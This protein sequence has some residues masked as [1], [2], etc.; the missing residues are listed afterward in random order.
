MM[1]RL[2]TV[3]LLSGLLTSLMALSIKDIQYTTDASGDSPYKDQVVTVSG[4]VTAEPYAFDGR[5]FFIQDSIGAWSGVM[6]YWSA[7]PDTLLISE[8]DWVTVTGTVKEY[9]GVTEIADITAFSIDEEAVFSIEPIDVTTG[10]VA[11]DGENAESYEGVLVRVND[12]DI[13][14]DMNNYGEWNVNDGSGDLMVDDKADFYFNPDEYEDCLSIT[15]VMDYSYSNFR[16]YP[17]LAWDI[18]EG[19]KTGEDKIYTRIQ[20]IQQ[21]R[22]SDLVK[23]AEG[24]GT[25]ASYMAEADIDNPDTTIIVKGVVTMPTGLS[26]AGDGIKFILQDLEGGPWSSILSYNEDS[27]AYP[28]LYEGDLIEMTGFVGEYS[29]G[30]ANMTEFWLT[31]A[32]EILDYGLETPVPDT[33]TTG[34]IRL[35]QTAEQYGNNMVTVVDAIV[36]ELDI[37]YYIM[38]IDDGTGQAL[39][40]DDSDSLEGYIAPPLMTPI[41]SITGWV[42]HHYGSYADSTTYNINPLYMDDI[43]LGDGPAMLLDPSRSPAG[44]IASTDAVT[45]GVTIVTNREIVEAKVF[46]RVDEGDYVGLDLVKDLDDG[47]HY[48]EIPQQ[49]DHAFVDYYFYVIDNE[50]D[51]SYLPANYQT[52]NF[53]YL[54]VDETP[55]IRD[56]QYTHWEN[57]N[58]PFEGIEVTVYGTVTTDAD[59]V[60]NTFVSG[61]LSAIAIADGAGPWNGIFVLAPTAD[62]AEFVEGDQVTVTGTVTDDFE[63]YW[64]WQGNTYIVASEVTKT[65]SGTPIEAT[66]V[67][68]QDLEENS[69]M[70]EGVLVTTGE[71]TIGAI[72]QYD[73]TLTDGTYEFLFDDD[74]V[75][76]SIFDINSYSD[77]V[78]GGTDTLLAGATFESVSGVVIHSYGTIKLEVRKLDDLGAVISSVEGFEPLLPES[79]A[80]YQNY[81][82]PFNPLTKIAFDLPEANMVKIVVYNLQGQMVKTIMNEF[83]GPGHHVWYWDGTNKFNQKV[84]TGTYIYRI[85]AGNFTDVKKMTFVK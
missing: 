43:V 80:L 31:G 32:V 15:G 28:I 62:F 63:Q 34:D 53:S 18:V 77:A 26:Y 41:E 56:L 6:V 44:K 5:T 24:E 22:Y 36:S 67:T 69:E 76:D 25:D 83:K 54:V 84:S 16:L 65:G 3:V 27:T 71:A 81:P 37:N 75:P 70:Y 55:M 85:K 9:Y 7:I 60:A 58:S 19:Y 13:T 66:T 33:V 57:G 29:T 50:D 30:P 68:L 42:Y 38:G 79:Y 52:V 12:V 17:R 51:V 4:E 73:L 2:L 11:T 46:Y 49:A 64:R 39:V 45:V 78:V 23:A 61:G 59:P 47:V 20:R 35:P 21:V 48:A 72:N 8:G 10:E 74:F 1:K 40:A 14:S 82:N